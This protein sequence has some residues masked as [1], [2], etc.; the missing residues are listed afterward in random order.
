MK[1]NKKQKRALISIP[2]VFVRVVGVVTLFGWLLE[3]DQEAI[4]RYFRAGI[5]GA[6][7]GSLL[8]LLSLLFN[9]PTN[10]KD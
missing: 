6:I 9:W 3:G 7:G 5:A 1:L 2:I 4:G 10:L 8:P